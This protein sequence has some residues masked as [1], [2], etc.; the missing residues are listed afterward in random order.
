VAT[1]VYKEL[2][3]PRAQ[4][5]RDY[6]AA[7]EHET[8]RDISAYFAVSETV[9]R[10]WMERNEVKK[11]RVLAVPFRKTTTRIEAGCHICHENL[12]THLRCS[13]CTIL[14]HDRE[15][16]ECDTCGD[17]HGKPTYRGSPVCTYCTE[18]YIGGKAATNGNPVRGNTNRAT[19]TKVRH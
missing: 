18:T 1:T 3:D 7:H 5:V 2:L 4:E 9:L 12:K 16:P 13:I 8:L 10:K 11:R 17:R 14:M 15:E 6:I 19:H